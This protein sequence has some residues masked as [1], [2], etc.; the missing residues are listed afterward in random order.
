[1][2]WECLMVTSSAGFT[3]RVSVHDFISL[4]DGGDWLKV[5]HALAICLLCSLIL[6]PSLSLSF[7]MQA[8]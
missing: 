1:M 5:P 4:G 8:S 6:S 3:T 2:G 7:S